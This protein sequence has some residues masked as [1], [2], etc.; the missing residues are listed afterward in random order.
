MSWELK[1]RRAGNSTWNCLGPAQGASTRLPK[2]QIYQQLPIKTEPGKD[3]LRLPVCSLWTADRDGAGPRLG[4]MGLQA[5]GSWGS[6]PR[7]V[8]ESTKASPA[9]PPTH[10]YTH[11][12]Q[13]PTLSPGWTPPLP[14]PRSQGD[15]PRFTHPVSS[16]PSSLFPFPW[17]PNQT[18][19]GEG[20]GSCA[21]RD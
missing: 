8:A 21:G 18:H 3:Q 14:T 1:Q 17:Q 13:A 11:S 5:N 4:S 15:R 7:A 10:T 2:A 16:L 9:S 20:P 19:Q 12:C 6:E